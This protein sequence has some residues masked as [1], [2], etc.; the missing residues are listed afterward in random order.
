LPW[1][2]KGDTTLVL[3]SKVHYRSL[4]NL[5]FDENGS[6]EFLVDN[7]SSAFIYNDDDYKTNSK[8]GVHIRA[9]QGTSIKM[10]AYPK[11]GYMLD[12]WY[13]DDE[14]I[15]TES[16]YLYQLPIENGYKEI[17]IVAKFK[18]WEYIWDKDGEDIPCHW[19]DYY[20]FVK[21]DKEN[22]PWRVVKEIHHYINDEWKEE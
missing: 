18:P 6:A 14:L 4:C 19:N 5:S 9:R 8:S 11:D 16:E 12:G 15:S 3:K 21:T 13:I 2:V 17:N 22:T 10:K 1:L 20:I 7:N